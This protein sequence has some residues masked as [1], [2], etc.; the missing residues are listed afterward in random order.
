M[1]HCILAAAS[2]NHTV[3]AFLKVPVL[4]YWPSQQSCSE[5]AMHFWAVHL[6]RAVMPKHRADKESL[7]PS[8]GLTWLHSLCSSFMSG[9][10]SNLHLHF[11]I[12]P[13]NNFIS[14]S[15]PQTISPHVSSYHTIPFALFLRSASFALPSTVALPSLSTSPLSVTATMIMTSE[16]NA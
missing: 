7:T 13:P 3:L 11:L 16:H 5:A 9:L 14:Y 12:F 4:S 2:H 6:L 1:G 15:S 10:H 8:P